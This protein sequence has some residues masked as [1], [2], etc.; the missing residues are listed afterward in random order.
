LIAD[1]KLIYL[2]TA[3]FIVRSAYQM[4][5]TPLLPIFALTLGA[6]DAYLGLIVSVSTLTGM[7][8]KPWIGLF[9]DFFGRRRWLLLGTAVF[10]LMPFAYGFIET[11]QQL[12]GVRIVHGL[13]TAIYGPVTLAYVVEHSS[14]NCAER[15]GWFSMARTAGYIV[16]PGVAGWLLLTQEPV[17]VFTTIGLL[18]CAAFLPI[19]LLDDGTPG[20]TP[21]CR[22]S[23]KLVFQAFNNVGRKPAVWLAGG[24]ESAMYV[25][26][27]ALKAFLPVYA[28][29]T[30]INIALVG[31]FFSAQEATH[32]FM[33]PWGGRL[34]DRL[35]YLPTVAMGM[36]I[37][38]VS[39]PL[40]PTVDREGLLLLLA[41]FLGSSEALIVP[42]AVALASEQL[43]TQNVGTGMGLIGTFKNAGKVAGP[44]IAGVLIGKFDFAATLNILGVV[45]LL[46]AIV[47]FGFEVVL[48][49]K[50]KLS[51]LK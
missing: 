41:V 49:K 35:G 38:S 51:A 50:R 15:L 3:D 11:P 20:Q 46:G 26:L 39:I 32:L 34:G 40:I 47:I 7:V 48:R 22:P 45:L 25:A 14:Q 44:I 33:K 16:G 37:L 19:L 4:G 17:R 42:S 29:S 5:K 8:L 12:F 6:S 23:R 30:G 27:Y 36:L 31:I 2:T 24:L 1:R 18:S 43:Q 21:R 10:A 13:A 9:S 28:V